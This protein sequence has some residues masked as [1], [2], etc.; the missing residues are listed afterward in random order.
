MSKKKGTNKPIAEG[1]STPVKVNPWVTESRFL[2]EGAA[3][4]KIASRFYETEGSKRTKYLY[5][6]QFDPS[7]PYHVTQSSDLLGPGNHHFLFCVL[8]LRRITMEIPQFPKEL[9]EL[10]L[11]A[12]C[13][14]YQ[15]MIVMSKKC[16]LT[17]LTSQTLEKFDQ[18]FDSPNPSL[19]AGSAAGYV[20][21]EE[22]PVN[23]QFEMRIVNLVNSVPS[24]GTYLLSG[25]AYGDP[26][27]LHVGGEFSQSNGGLYLGP[28]S[29][30]YYA[31]GY[32]WGRYGGCVQAQSND[33]RDFNETFYGRGD[34]I[35]VLIRHKPK[36]KTLSFHKNGARIKPAVQISLDE[37]LYPML[38]NF[39]NVLI[40]YRYSRC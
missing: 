11:L 40:S 32:V 23:H 10:I 14:L 2:S 18:L 29:D 28:K 1:E 30:V 31:Y 17:Q 24:N 3:L 37:P 19:T 16:T 39:D 26:R 20:Y 9:H 8:A 38:Y 6:V 34:V 13:Q 21:F 5:A 25:A 4:N 35:D 22:V 7:V 33:E 27:T 36:S 12:L 15:C